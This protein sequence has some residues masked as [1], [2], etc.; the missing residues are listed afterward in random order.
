MR[1]LKYTITTISAAAVLG[2]GALLA[3]VPQTGNAMHHR[4]ERREHMAAYLGLTDA[5]KAQA[6]TIWQNARE[7]S[8]PLRQELR[9]ERQNVM[10]AAKSGK[11]EQ[12]IQ[13]LAKVE[14]PQLA[15]LSAIRAS[16]FEK[17]YAMLTPAQQQKLNAF[18]QA[19]HQHR[20]PAANQSGE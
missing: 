19:H 18:Q 15:Q 12:E 6:K 17:F 7:N 11:S 2:A 8:K 4:G 16:A 5:Q 3:A 13:R 14:G 20:G 1:S 10:A 9:Q